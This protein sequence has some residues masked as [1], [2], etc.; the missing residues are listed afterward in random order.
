MKYRIKTESGWWK[1]F[2]KF[3]IPMSGAGTKDAL[4]F[5]SKMDAMHEARIIPALIG[6]DELVPIKKEG[7]YEQRSN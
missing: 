5:N 2:N 1:G 4:I 6:F 7:K 3:G